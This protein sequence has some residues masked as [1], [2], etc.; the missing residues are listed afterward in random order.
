MRSYDDM[1]YK[2]Y[3]QSYTVQYNHTEEKFQSYAERGKFIH[4]SN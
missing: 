2:R 4:S 3:V 1:Y